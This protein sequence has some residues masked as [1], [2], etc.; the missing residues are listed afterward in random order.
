MRSKTFGLPKQRKYPMPDASHARNAKARASAEYK[1]GNLTRKQYAMI[2][3]KANRII[4]GCGGDPA[5]VKNPKGKTMKKNP[6][7]ET[8]GLE[9]FID[10]DAELYHQRTVPIQKNLVKKKLAGKFDINKAPKLFGYLVEAGAKKYAQDFGG[11][12]NKIFSVQDRKSVAQAMAREF[13]EAYRVGDYDHLIE[14]VA[15]VAYKR[16]GYTGAQIRSMAPLSKKTPKKN[17]KKNPRREVR[18][19]SGD[20]RYKI[21]LEETGVSGGRQ[22]GGVSFYKQNKGGDYRHIGSAVW[23]GT[24]FKIGGKDVPARIKELAAHW[25]YRAQQENKT[26]I[27]VSLDK[28][29]QVKRVLQDYVE[30]NPEKRPRYEIRRSP[31]GGFEVWDRQ[32]ERPVTVRFETEKRATEALLKLLEKKKKNPKKKVIMKIPNPGGKMTKKQFEAYFK[33]EVLPIIIAQY[34]PTDKPA[35]REGWNNVVD[36]MMKAKLLPARAGDWAHPKWLETYKP[37]RSNPKRK[38]VKRKVKKKVKRKVR[39]KA[40]AR[41]VTKTTSSKSVTVTKNPSRAISAWMRL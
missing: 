7:H 37:R 26:L 23:N 24:N 11:T 39:R 34:G 6:E 20:V 33:T 35:R 4:K 29:G 19:R 16:A 5:P 31:I 21:I 17:P 32:A 8:R 15:P 30:K 22:V 27:E 36:A 3:R 28:G 41:R 12:W 25:M 40:P 9:L 10:N 38:K 13:D 2:Q 18:I 14:E 1:R